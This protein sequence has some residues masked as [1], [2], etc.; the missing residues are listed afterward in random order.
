MKKLIKSF[1]DKDEEPKGR[2]LNHP[3]EL[4]IGDV[5]VMDDGFDLPAQLRGQQFEVKQVQTT[6]FEYK[7]LTG[8]VLKGVSERPIFLG[9]EEE[10]GEAYLAFSIKVERDEVEQIFDLDEFSE[11]FETEGAAV[12][13]KQGDLGGFD[14]WVAP[15]YRQTAHE[16]RGYFYEEDYRGRKVPD[17]EGVGEPFNY[18][19]LESDDDDHQVEIEVWQDGDTD[20]LLTIYRPVADIKEM[21]PTK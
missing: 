1:F 19:C 17:Y 10:D 20:V 14:N 21:W 7:Q 16:E 15:I 5:I 13:N 11:I 18:Y 8:W 4:N 12:I 3:R 9:V 6:Q 2:T